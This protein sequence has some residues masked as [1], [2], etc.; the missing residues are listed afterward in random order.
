[1]R[2]LHPLIALVLTGTPLLAAGQ[3]PRTLAIEDF[4]RVRTVGAPRIAPSGAW[5]AW[6]VT[7]RVEATNA[8][9]SE[10]W[11]AASDLRGP[12]RRVSR[13]GTD[14]TAP[15]WEGDRLVFRSGGRRWQIDPARADSLVDLGEIRPPNPAETFLA[16]PI[17]GRAVL[18]KDLPA[19]PM[20]ADTRTE[21][22]QRHD[23]RFQGREFDWLNFQ[24]DGARYPVPDPTNPRLF[25]AQ[26]LWLTT[27]NG[28]APRLLTRL[29]L[30]PRG[31]QWNAQG[32]ALVFWADSGYRDERRYAANAVYVAHVDGTVRQLTTDRDVDHD[33]AAFSPDGRWVVYTRQLSRN[34]I[35]ARKLNHGGA[36][37]LAI[38]PVN[39]GPERL[40]TGDWD[41]LPEGAKWSADS[42]FVYF[43]AAI[44]G[45]QH[46]F[47]VPVN[48]GAVE[49]VTSGARRLAN[50]TFDRATTRIAY[51]ATTTDSPAEVFTAGIDGTGEQRLSDANATLRA[52]VS[53]V[54]AERLQFPSADGTRIE[55]F[56]W[57]PHGYDPAKRYPLVVSNH[58]GP[59][60][61]DGYAWDFKTQY[62]A[63]NGYFVLKV[64]FRSSTGYGEPF[65]W[66]TW[67]AWGTK[68]GQDV[69]AGV[70]HVLA[71][72]PVDR[73]RVATM[74]HSYGGF[75]SNWLITQYPDRFAAAI[76]GAGIVNWVSDYGT[77]DIAV[78]KE[79]EFFGTPWDSTAREIMIRQ[80]PL[81][82]AGRVRT[83]TLFVHGEIDERVP[84]SEAEQM[85]VALK[86]NGVPAAIIQYKDM[87]HGISG[88]W[89][90]IHRLLHERRWLDQWLKAAVT[91]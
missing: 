31:V 63:A 53:F 19:P 83:P 65:L 46:L 8:E 56:L 34:A 77:A 88:S 2:F 14:A 51:T 90:N 60:S 84:Y 87:P 21:F 24:R 13:D 38:R 61:A 79:T 36:T 68:D 4:Y 76:P 23:S 39:G 28:E 52:D 69:M 78:T 22:E 33:E 5:V 58:G 48:G 6:T 18:L 67:G 72:W 43:S 54:Q 29:G 3:G 32:T 41:L 75:M 45:A 9:P 73:S 85:F 25:P 64:N 35:I 11:L 62:L 27:V 20:A 57:K 55:G 82:Y 89:N 71:R 59:H 49:Q 12:A 47:R 40:L 15:Q 7:S 66:A 80:S 70:D 17:G 1:M 26:E 30:R 74:G 42:R 81:T 16:A 86:K 44:A 37:D 91:P 50:I 10:V